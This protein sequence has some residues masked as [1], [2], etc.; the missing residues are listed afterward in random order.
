[1]TRRKKNEPAPP[2]A[3]PPPPPGPAGY[4]LSL[5]DL[6][7]G[8]TQGLAMALAH[9]LMNPHRVCKHCGYEGATSQDL[10][11]AH[12]W[13]A[14]NEVLLL[15]DQAKA[16]FV[17]KPPPPITIELPFTPPEIPENLG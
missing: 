1:M 6:A 15:R 12:R 10:Q 3:P 13:L 4:S 11:L 9:R 17:T 16:E 8:L 5:V 7:R 14:D 2:P